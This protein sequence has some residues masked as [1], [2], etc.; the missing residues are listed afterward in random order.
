MAEEESEAQSATAASKANETDNLYRH[1]SGAIV[2]FGKQA[3][4]AAAWAKLVLVVGGAFLAS[5]GQFFPDP[6]PGQPDLGKIVG[7]AG[8]ILALVGSIWSMRMERSEPDNLIKAHEAI[9]LAKNAQVEIV[10]KN[11]T[12]E[13]LEAELGQTAN[14]YFTSTTLREYVE[15]QIAAR[16]PDIAKSIQGMVSLVSRSLREL[17]NVNGGEYWT[18]AIYKH[19][20]VTG[21]EGNLTYLAGERSEPKDE[22]RKHR[23]WAV[24]EGVAGHCYKIG[25]ELIIEDVTDRDTAGWIYISPENQQGDDR[26]KYVSFAAIPVNVPHLSRPWGVIVATSDEQMRFQTDGDGK[27]D[28]EIEPIRMIGGMVA[29][30]AGANHLL[31]ELSGNAVSGKGPTP[32]MADPVKPKG[33]SKA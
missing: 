8:V 5:A 27:G 2:A 7:W 24:G 23:D 20:P 11:E 12:I 16:D 31:E 18:L 26:R 21:G 10:A 15:T 14:L 1:F 32:T 29:V 28:W 6:P 4:S 17:M 25:R 9:D 19:V 22:P 33:A 3:N 13:E 30:L